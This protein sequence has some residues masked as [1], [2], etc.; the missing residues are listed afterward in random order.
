MSQWLEGVD[1]DLESWLDKEVFLWF[2][3]VD[4]EGP[5]QLIYIC[6]ICKVIHAHMKL[7]N[8][9]SET[10]T[11]PQCINVLKEI[12]NVIYKIYIDDVLK[13]ILNVI[14]KIYIGIIN[15]LDEPQ[16]N[17][18]QMDHTTNTLGWES[19]QWVASFSTH[20]SIMFRCNKETHSTSII[21]VSEIEWQKSHELWP[22]KPREDEARQD[23]RDFWYV[24]T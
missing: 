22:S 6:H 23:C 5:L 24:R 18:Q 20:V 21:Q 9:L 15:R 3:A 13:E 14:Y 2:A 12:L 11:L 1:I 17:K 7:K 8:Y 10:R 19:M 16:N 4:F